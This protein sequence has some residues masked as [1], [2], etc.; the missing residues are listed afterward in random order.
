MQRLWDNMPLDSGDRVQSS[1][2]AT[3]NPISL[4]PVDRTKYAQFIGSLT[5][6][7]CTEGVVWTVLRQVV[8]ASPDQIALFRKLI[9]TNARPVQPL[10]GRLIKA[11]N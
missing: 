9:G 1:E 5:T 8:T 2:G 10:N 4:L 6:P 7:P 3:F 11:S